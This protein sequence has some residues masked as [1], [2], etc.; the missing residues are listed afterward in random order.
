M[1]PLIKIVVCSLC[2][3]KTWKLYSIKIIFSV[4]SRFFYFNTT[5]LIQWIKI[6]FTR[7]KIC[8]ILYLNYLNKLLVLDYNCCVSFV[9]VRLV[10]S[11]HW[12]LNQESHV[13]D[14]TKNVTRPTLALSMWLD[15]SRLTFW[16]PFSEEKD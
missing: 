6:Q 3:I 16:K 11:Q 10:S 15:V 14:K 1:Q 12:A 9:T 7:D 5:I 8:I 13:W 2:R 4:E